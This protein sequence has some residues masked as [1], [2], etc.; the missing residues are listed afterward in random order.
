MKK[1]KSPSTALTPVP[2]VLV[3]VASADGR[4]NIITLAWVGTVNSEP[5]MISIS[6]RPSRYSH[7]LLEET[8]EFVVNLPTED[9]VRELDLC[10]MVS[11]RDQDKFELCGF[12]RESAS[13]V[14]APLIDRCPVNIE[15]VVR[16]KM[17]LGSHDL[18]I[19]EILAVHVDGDRAGRD[20]RARAPRRATCTSRSRIR[21]PRCGACS[22]P[23]SSTSGRWQTGFRPSPRSAR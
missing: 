9:M 6:V 7:R 3:T 1:I 18:Y 4:D 5:P 13:E 19:G 22:S 20:A 16:N 12:G 14:K 17:S 21:A 2:A 10:G 23:R 11:G 8:G 15:C